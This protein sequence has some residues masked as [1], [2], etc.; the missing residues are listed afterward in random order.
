M[1]SIGGSQIH[2][3]P[4]DEASSSWMGILRF[5]VSGLIVTAGGR[6]VHHTPAHPYTSPEEQIIFGV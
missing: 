3:H 6:T 4:M 5:Q 2:M 1:H